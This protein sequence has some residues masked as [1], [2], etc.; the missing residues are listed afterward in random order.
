MTAKLVPTTKAAAHLGVSR[1]TFEKRRKAGDP[2]YQPDH[3]DPDSGWRSYD[4]VRIDEQRA[5]MGRL[6]AARAFG[7]A[8]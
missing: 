4:L 1:H 5:E 7:G 3:V 6:R 2:L 8:A